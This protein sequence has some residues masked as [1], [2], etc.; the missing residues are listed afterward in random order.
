V[1]LRYYFH[2]V[3][4]KN[5]VINSYYIVNAEV[6][7][8]ELNSSLAYLDI[9]IDSIP[10]GVYPNA[11]GFSIGL[12]YSDWS[13]WNKA[14]DYSYQKNSVYAKNSKILLFQGDSLIYGVIPAGKV[15]NRNFAIT[16]FRPMNLGWIE[17]ENISDSSQSTD[18]LTLM[19]SKGNLHKVGRVALKPKG[20]IKFCQNDDACVISNS[21][22]VDSSFLWGENG[23][24]VLMKD[25]LILSY[26]PWGKEGSFAEKAVAVDVW[27]NKEDFFPST[28][29]DS[30]YGIEYEKNVYFKINPF[31]KITNTE[32]W[33]YYTSN[34]SLKEEPFSPSPILLSTNKEKTY[35]MKGDDSISFNWQQVR[36]VSDYQLVVLSETDSSLI[37][38]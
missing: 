34:D 20:K 18:G 32:G 28:E 17:I 13:V 8:K 25:S 14:V 12:H 19:D 37:E 5:V 35:R 33:W 30:I 1:K 21:D 9:K 38:K 31:A 24:A 4:N 26:I 15:E 2:N 11:S 22:V 10:P 36:N 23:E 3:E 7:W 16:G 27:D 29:I 6:L